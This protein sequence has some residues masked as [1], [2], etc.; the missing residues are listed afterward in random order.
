VE[1]VAQLG[2]IAA[3]MEKENQNAANAVF[4]M[5]KELSHRGR[6]AYGLASAKQQISAKSLEK[7]NPESVRSN[8]AIGH[9]FC[10]ILQQDTPQ[11]LQTND[12]SLAF[13]GRIYP[14]SEDANT[15]KIGEKLKPKPEKFP[16]RIIK[17]YD[18]TY[19]FAIVTPNSLILGRDVLGLAPLYLAK[20]E[21]LCAFASE[22]KA[23]WKLGLRNV[24]SFPPG[25]MAMVKNDMRLS[26][27]DLKKIRQPVQQQLELE[28]AAKHL[29]RLLIRSTLNMTS[30]TKEVAVAF[31]GGLDSSLVAFLAQECGAKVSLINVGLENMP[32]TKYAEA[33]AKALKMKIQVK[34]YSVDSVEA[35][36]PKVLWLIEEPNAVNASIAIP[37]YWTSEVAANLG[38]RVLMAGQGADELFGGYHRYVHTYSEKGASALRKELFGDVIKCYMTNFQ[39]DNQ[40]CMFHNVELRLPFA[41][42]QV[43]NFALSLPVKLKILSPTDWLR[44]RVLRKTAENLGLPKFI[45][46]KA[47]KA[48]QYAT[49]VDKALRELAKRENLNSPEYC[50]KVFRNL[51]PDVE[52]ND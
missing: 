50:R 21:T 34:T 37:L 1:N 28:P 7:L 51:F 36:L 4:T 52:Y 43:V 19:A 40:T 8:I 11:L 17:K 9:A 18:G 41:D 16:S 32:E 12:F 35:V 42:L 24:E 23:L 38:L 29:Q 31:S 26:F 10:K 46:N 48:V 3:I 27:K 25:S 22:R 6:D 39:R 49:G 44:K 45:A 33:A 2:A 5:I 47:K 30:D 14:H 13:E 15:T 20:N